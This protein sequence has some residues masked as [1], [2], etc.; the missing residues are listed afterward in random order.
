MTTEALTI[1]RFF[2]LDQVETV[3]EE[4]AIITLDYTPP[5]ILPEDAELELDS[6]EPEPVVT[7]SPIPDSLPSST[8]FSP[9]VWFVGSLGVFLVLMLLVDAYHFVAQQ[10]YS[11][12]FLGSVFL[13]L[14]V[15]ISGAA[16]TLTWRSYQHLRRLRTV[17]ALQKEGK[18]L[19][20][21]NDYGH[22]IQYINRVMLFYADRP[23]VKARAERFYLTMN[24]SHHDS[25]VCSLFS[26][27]V[28]KDIDQQAHRI[29]IQRSKETALM[30]M[31]SQ[32]A[33]LD[34]I[35]TLWRNVRMIRDIASLYGGRPGFFGS[36]G[37]IS[38]VLQ[39]LIYADVS[40]MVAGSVAEILGSSMLSVMSA[41]VAQGLGS[42][43]LTARL[44]LHAM[45]ACR[46]LPFSEEEKPRLTH[47]RREIMS[48]M[49]EIFNR[50]T[51]QTQTN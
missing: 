11:S 8:G 23:E 16:L 51:S 40:E 2:E 49:T 26:S 13:G 35:L 17:S 24:D 1:P 5:V 7:P 34:A 27:Q 44:G 12:F 25:E 41:Q 28:M 50:K 4:E 10:F 22:A 9:W 19:M 37:L 32:I 3:A 43:V 36:I 18:Q 45:Q 33:L 21:K 39:N 14:M 47:I 20:E 48:S 29:V 42:G 30:V 6:Y 31:I 38:G 15:A 46:P